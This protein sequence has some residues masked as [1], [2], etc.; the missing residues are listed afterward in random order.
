M[1]IYIPA[2]LLFFASCKNDSCSN[3]SCLNGGYCS[4]GQC[5]CINPYGGKNCE[6]DLC[7]SVVCHNGGFCVSGICDCA[8]GYEGFHCDSLVTTKFTGT[9]TCVPACG[10]VTVLATGTASACNITFVSLSGIQPVA[11]VSSYAINIQSQT[12]QTGQTISGSGQMSP[13]RDSITLNMTVIPYGSTA[14]ATYNYTL[15]RQ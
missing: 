15:I 14:S 7:D 1:R 6:T 3:F 10:N 8:T 13:N 9:F 11:V 4:E 5:R 12:L 2:L